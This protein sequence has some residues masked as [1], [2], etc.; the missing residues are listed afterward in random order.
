MLSFWDLPIILVTIAFYL[1][2]NNALTWRQFNFQFIKQ[3]FHK[4][5]Y[6]RF[7]GKKPMP[8]NP[9]NSNALHL[10]HGKA[11]GFLKYA[12]ITYDHDY[13]YT[14]DKAASKDPDWLL[15]LTKPQAL[16]HLKDA[17]FDKIIVSNCICCT[18]D[19]A[20]FRGASFLRSLVRLL[21]PQ[22]RLYVKNFPLFGGGLEPITVKLLNEVGLRTCLGKTLVQSTVNGFWLSLVKEPKLP[23]IEEEP[24]PKEEEKGEFMCKGE[25]MTPSRMHT[26]LYKCVDRPNTDYSEEYIS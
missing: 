20:L 16:A 18:N 25:T 12:L 15:D 1:G 7:Y 17:L 22:G 24:L 23:L 5:K 11:D 10:F 9:A 14:V 2:L 13:T 3:F 8:P 4:R 26:P 19:V 6:P 21:K